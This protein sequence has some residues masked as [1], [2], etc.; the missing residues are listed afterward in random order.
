M[1]V[2]AVSDHMAKKWVVTALVL[3]ALF[4][5]AAYA[6]V[7]ARESPVP[8]P[9]IVVL[10]LDDYAA[11]DHRILER[12]PTIKSVFLER[13]TEFT[14]YW[15]N[16]PLC[17]PGRANFLTGQYA[18]HHGVVSND[19][20]LLDPSMTIATAL[21]GVGYY[22]SM[23]GKYFNLAG[24]LENKTP[25]GWDNTVFHTAGYYG[26]TMWVNGVPED[27]GSLPEDYSTDVFA[28]QC[29]EFLAAAPVDQPLFAFM[30]PLAVHGGYDEFGVLKTR[31][32]VP[33]P[34]HRGDPQCQGIEKWRPPNYDPADVSGKPAYVRARPRLSQEFAGGLELASR[35]EALLSVDQWLSE[36]VDVL[37]TQGRLSNTLFVLTA[38]NGMGWGAHRSLLKHAPYTAA[39]PLFVSW[40]PFDGTE[41]TQRIDLVANVD[42]APTLCDIAGCSLGP[43]TN[44]FAADGQ[45]FAGLVAPS[46]FT[47]K[48]TRDSFI[49]ENNGGGDSPRWRG[50]MTDVRHALGRQFLYITYST[51]E[52]ELYRVGRVPC[53]QWTPG[54][55]ADP[56][57][58]TNLAKKARYGDIRRGLAAELAREW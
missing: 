34:R 48:P 12:L 24:R 19:A 32:P 22:T 35:C 8:P 41:L 29:R 3:C 40:A 56:C 7:Q 25:P 17:C 1:R 28:A 23:C 15:G 31:E 37:Q 36:V 20:R 10:M 43:F 9:N 16:N 11:S 50:L 38:D 51:G 4:L 55:T 57:M 58:L 33:A 18:H 45:S 52:R 39:M 5:D 6:P 14:N 54:Q 49:L 27:H 42:L 2:Q 53:Y 46:L 47:S 21:D 26:Y 13:G 30:T 44:G